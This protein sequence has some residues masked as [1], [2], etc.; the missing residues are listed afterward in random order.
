MK[1]YLL[2]AVVILSFS[3]CA[4]HEMAEVEI[5][6]TKYTY[7]ENQV[8]AFYQ[9]VGSQQ[10]SVVICDDGTTA[11]TFT[12]N[13]NIV[14]NYNCTNG[15][16]AVAIIYITYDGDH[17]STQYS[18][19]TG[20]INLVSAGGN[21]IEGTFGGTIKNSSGTYTITVANGKFSGQA[22]H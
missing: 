20:N 9:T 19:S 14:G 10:Q 2:M 15:A 22:P 5:Q 6:G 7:N 3:A 16:G 8:T 12:V 21:L 11:L 17:F 13:S 4:Y 1:K 18:G